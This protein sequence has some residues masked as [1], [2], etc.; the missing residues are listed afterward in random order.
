VGEREGIELCIWKSVISTNQEGIM[1]VVNCHERGWEQ[2]CRRGNFFP[3]GQRVKR[4]LK[5]ATEWVTCHSIRRRHK[6]VRVRI[7][8][9]PPFIGTPPS[10]YTPPN[11][12]GGGV[13]KYTVLRQKFA[14]CGENHT[15][16]LF[17]LRIMLALHNQFT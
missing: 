16:Q 17:Y 5:W 1:K 12:E 7:S 14:F 9:H 2:R 13:V 10:K 3:S 15:P 11:Q 8:L 4:R 6:R